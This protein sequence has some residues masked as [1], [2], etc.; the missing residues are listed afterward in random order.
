M[1][2]KLKEL[3][4]FDSSQLPTSILKS[5]NANAKANINKYIN[6]MFKQEGVSV[7]VTSFDN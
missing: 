7:M 6:E 3:F 2:D 4:T 5:A 1:Q